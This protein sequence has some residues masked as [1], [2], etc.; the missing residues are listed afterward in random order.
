MIVSLTKASYSL[1]NGAPINVLDY[2][3][4]ATGATSSSAAIQLALNTGAPEVFFPAGSYLLNT[5][6]TLSSLQRIVGESSTLI[7][8]NGLCGA[9]TANNTP[10]ITMAERST[11]S[12]FIFKTQTQP[13]INGT[14]TAPVVHPYC[15]GVNGCSYTTIENV[16][17]LAC[18]RG[19][20]A[21]NSAS[22]ECMTIQ[23]MRGTIFETPVFIDQNTDVD[24]LLDIQLNPTY[25]VYYGGAGN[26][27]TANI[28]AYQRNT[29]NANAFTI[30]KSDWLQ[31]NNCFAYGYKRGILLE[32][33]TATVSGP[34]TVTV[35]NSGFDGCE[36]CIVSS[37]VINA[38][39]DNVTM[40]A[41]RLASETVRDVFITGAGSFQFTNCFFIGGTYYG[42]EINT[43]GSVSVVNCQMTDHLEGVVVSNGRINLD[44]VIF[45]QAGG[46]I[47]DINL[48]GTASA[49]IRNC[50]RYDGSSSVNNGI[51]STTCPTTYENGAINVSYL[52]FVG[53]KGV[54]S[55]FI[56]PQSIANGATYY[57]ATLPAGDGNYLVY[58]GEDANTN[59]AN[60][61]IAY[62]RTGS[63][64]SAVS[65]LATSGITIA[66]S[67]LQVGVTNSSGGTLN[68]DFGYLKLY[69]E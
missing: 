17:F 38:S 21:G 28:I 11:V 7:I 39:F 47:Y 33:G 36:N 48:S 65:V 56:A 12:G 66:I 67:G 23:N 25:A 64:G 6:L 9:G 54:A 30:R 42:M 20:V 58:A 43:S 8:G 14:T 45:K 49:N 44:T 37:D 61:A 46:T 63:T 24:R 2:G 10:I 50:R 57:F 18:W 15:I 69:Q 52:P 62:V 13:V 51:T 26:F 60:R 16:D 35:S 34:P 27:V 68:V 55:A 22:H 31:M 32:T 1:I 3:A 29:A 19:V 40:A 41:I 4:D 5:V 59:G 53:T